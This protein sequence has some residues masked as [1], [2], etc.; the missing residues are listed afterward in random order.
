MENTY[1][2]EGCVLVCVT[3]QIACKRLIKAGEMVAIKNNLPMKVLSIFPEGD[4]LKSDTAPIME[5]LYE[6]ARLSDATMSVYFNDE[7]AILTAVLAK[8][9]DAGVLIT[10]FP[11]ERSTAFVSQIHEILPDLPIIMI[12]DNMKQYRIMPGD[13]VIL[14]AEPAGIE[15]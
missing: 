6:A 2:V 3:P 12:D 14:S 11:R 9:E 5:A 13:E 1:A 10:G 7:P 15:I 8:K 4:S